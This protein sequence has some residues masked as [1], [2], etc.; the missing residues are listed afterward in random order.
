MARRTVLLRQHARSPRWLCALLGLTLSAGIAAIIHPIAPLWIH[1]ALPLATYLLLRHRWTLETRVEEG[2]EGRVLR[3]RRPR[4]SFATQ[5]AQRDIQS[6]EIH[7]PDPS[8]AHPRIDPTDPYAHHFSQWGYQGPSLT[9]RFQMPTGSGG[10]QQLRTWHFP[11]P[12]AARM[13]ALLREAG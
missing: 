11:A 12:E 4:D 8:S 5:V 1:L 9:V 7:S 13:C 3:L 2:P 6:I 10:E